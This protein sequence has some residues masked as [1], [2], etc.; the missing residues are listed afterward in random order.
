MA[1]HILEVAQAEQ[2]RAAAGGGVYGGGYCIAGQAPVIVGSVRMTPETD[3][4]RADRLARE[5]GRLT[6]ELNNARRALNDERNGF[7]TPHGCLTTTVPY[8]SGHAVVAY[9]SDDWDHDDG[10]TTTEFIAEYVWIGAQWVPVCE[11]G[12]FGQALQDG[13]AAAVEEE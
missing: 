6:Y 1:S 3:A 11:L 5:V 2:A 9:S 12:A 13:L 4:Q 7:K 8:D 10:S